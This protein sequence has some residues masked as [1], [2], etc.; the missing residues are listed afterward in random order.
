M[1]EQRYQ[2]GDKRKF[3]KSHNQIRKIDDVE[4]NYQEKPHSNWD[5]IRTKWKT[6][7]NLQNSGW[8][9][10]RVQASDK[11]FPIKQKQ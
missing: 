7:P 1:E 10:W 8:V 11:N 6:E 2:F 4:I 5:A 9:R 3:L